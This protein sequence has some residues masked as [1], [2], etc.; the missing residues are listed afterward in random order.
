MR[1]FGY[2]VYLLLTSLLIIA[3]GLTLAW[4]MHAG[5]ARLPLRQYFPRSH[6]N[7]IWDWSNPLNKSQANLQEASDFMYLHQLN[8]VYVNVGSY[9]TVLAEKDMAKKSAD[10]QQFEDAISHY[11]GVM[12]KRHIQVYAT[13][14]DSSWSDPKNR[15]IPRALLSAMQDY[16]DH[17]SKTRLA[18]VEFDIEAYNQTGFDTSSLTAK[19]LVLSDYLGLVDQLATSTAAYNA[20][21][22][23]AFE[24]GFT[25]PYWFDNENGNIPSITWHGKTGPTLYHLLDRLNQLPTSNIVVMAYRNAAR[26]NDGTIYH[27]RTEVEYAQARAPHVRVLIG[28]EVNDVEPAKITFYGESATELSSQVK[29]IEDEYAST[30]SFNGIAIN[31]L[32]GFQGMEGQR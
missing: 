5:V 19:S 3:L 32:A 30:S 15:T 29:I 11:I 28:Q 4:G 7:A 13:A 24:L 25:V 9:T 22:H 2:R 26:G 12:Q 21:T 6:T 16:N 23:T 20:R 18:G 10:R 31:D 17:H 14:G 8:T 27:S 1:R